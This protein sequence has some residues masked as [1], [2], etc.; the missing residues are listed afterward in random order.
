MIP[1]NGSGGP[2]F[3]HQ[4]PADWYPFILSKTRPLGLRNRKKNGQMKCSLIGAN[5]RSVVRHKPR[6]NETQ[7]GDASAGCQSIRLM[8]ATLAI[9]GDSLVMPLPAFTTRHRISPRNGEHAF[10]KPQVTRRGNRAHPT[11]E[12]LVAR[13]YHYVFAAGFGHS[14]VGPSGH[15]AACDTWRAAH[16]QRWTMWPTT[17]VDAG[18]GVIRLV[19]SCTGRIG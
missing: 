10:A 18:S 12:N 7:R 3:D 2:L 11:A 4:N 1:E 16:A 8:Q 5:T 19:P 9:R 6:L 14:R 15:R 13:N 17:A